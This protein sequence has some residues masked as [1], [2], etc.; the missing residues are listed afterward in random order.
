[1]TNY[2]TRYHGS[3]RISVSATQ[4]SVTFIHVDGFRMKK[5]DFSKAFLI[6]HK[7]IKYRFN[8]KILFSCKKIIIKQRN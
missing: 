8:L 2:T 4:K 6:L 3:F 7:P 5:K 1:M